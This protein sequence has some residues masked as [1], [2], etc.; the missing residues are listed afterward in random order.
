MSPVSG[1]FH[2]ELDDGK[3]TWNI[4][5]PHVSQFTTHPHVIMFHC[6]NIYVKAMV[7]SRFSLIPIIESWEDH[8]LVL[9][10]TSVTFVIGD[11]YKT[12]C[13]S[14]VFQQIL[15]WNWQADDYPCNAKTFKDWSDLGSKK[16][17]SRSSQAYNQETSDYIWTNGL[18]NDLFWW[19]YMLAQLV[20]KTT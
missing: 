1:H 13:K 12:G 20:Q 8:H 6:K 3:F 4:W 10:E 17:T 18:N 15:V 11:G 2:I 19:T 14:G 5:N 16:S 7:S 9:P